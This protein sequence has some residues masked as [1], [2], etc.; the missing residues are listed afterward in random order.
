MTTSTEPAACP[1]AHARTLPV[2]GTPLAPSP[3]LAAWRASDAAVPLEYQDGHVGMVVTRWEAARAVLGDPRFSQLPHRMPRSDAAP[4][5]DPA[6]ATTAPPPD[7]LDDAARRSI[8]A[9]N[10]LA[11]DGDAHRRMRRG[12]TSRFSVKQVRGREPWVHDTVAGQLAVFRALGPG[13]DVFADF[14]KPIAARTHCRVIGV[15]DD[16]V[17]QFRELFVDQVTTTT[18]QQRF[19]HIR[20]VL[21]RRTG[22]PGDDVVSDLLASGFERYE[23]EGLVFQLMSAGHDSVA[24]LI[25]TATVALLTNPD[26]LALLR[27]DPDRIAPAIEEFM[28]TGAMFLTLFP[29]T[30]TE[31]VVVDDQLVP[32]GTTVS[33]SPV[34]ANRDPERFRDPDRLDVE[35]DA[36]GHLGFGHGPHGCVGQQ[37]ARLEIRQALTQLLAGLPGLRLLD[38]DQLHP[39]PFANPVATYEAGAVHV[40][41]DQETAGT[42]GTGP[43]TDS[44]SICPSI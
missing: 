17:P 35:R 27:D 42:A 16:L 3:T 10:L 21:D 37:L 31:D 43:K 25:A 11:L 8:D 13:A 22:D 40:T 18:T 2:D 30:A 12:V 20:T 39:L 28:R 26:Q 44:R 33:V 7:T 23:V 41:W 34:G 29:R 5:H 9:A 6:H 38:A 15:P 4:A 19:D 1:F 14:A 36:F 32:A 24:Y